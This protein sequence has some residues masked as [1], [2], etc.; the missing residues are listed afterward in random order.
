MY[1]VS[2]CVP[3]SHL[4]SSQLEVLKYVKIRAYEVYVFVYVYLYILG[5]IYHK[6]YIPFD[7][8]NYKYLIT[9]LLYFSYACRDS[10]KLKFWTENPGKKQTQKAEQDVS[11]LSAPEPH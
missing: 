1:S 7:L 3:N 5:G 8:T 9:F 11:S 10:G 2:T 4:P 6:I